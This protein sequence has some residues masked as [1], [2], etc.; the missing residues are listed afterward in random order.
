MTLAVSFQDV[1]DAA[2]RLAGHAHRTPVLTSRTADEQLGA[3]LFFKCE[4]LQ[5]IGAFKFRGGY[6]AIAR[7]DDAQRRRGVLAFSSGNHA[8]AIALAARL[9]G[10]AAT[11]LM[12]ADA[13][14]AKMA[15]TRDYGAEVVTYD[16]MTQDREALARALADER[17]LSLIPPY[18]HPD[19][20]AGQGT[21]AL[22]LFE[23]VPALDKLVVCVGGGGLVS[24]C[25]LA[26]AGMAPGCEVHGVE[27]EAGNDVQQSLRAGRIVTIDVPRTIA[28]GAQTTHAGVLTFP[29]IQAHVRDVLTVTDA[30]LVETMRFFAERMKLVVEPTGCLAAAAVLQRVLDVKG[31]R[32]GIIV[33]GGNVDLAR[34]SSLLAGGA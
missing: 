33:S 26:A 13:P 5:R 4:N 27:P 29:I 17:G 12:P 31:A 22:E 20:I 28:D 34:F 18:D 2:A 23:E 8:Q 1:R 21:A 25:A 7:L 15:A 14:A 32:V 24:G 10:V 9:Q 11:I 3:R 30:Q 19:V 16:R 6:N